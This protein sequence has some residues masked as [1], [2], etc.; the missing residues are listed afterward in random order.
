MRAVLAEQ[1]P[2]STENPADFDLGSDEKVLSQGEDSPWNA[3][4]LAT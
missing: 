2:F 4:A 3:V 1:T